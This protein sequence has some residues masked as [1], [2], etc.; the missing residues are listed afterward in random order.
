MWGLQ[1]I[2]VGI[3]NI[4]MS[5]VAFFI[6]LRFL[7]TLFGANTATPFVS[8]VYQISGNL[9]YPF[10]GIFPNLVLT[11]GAAIDMVAIVALVDYSVIGY[12]AISVLGSL[13]TLE[14]QAH[15]H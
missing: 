3:I 5:V 7:L 10:Q 9:V 14:R 1:N 4:A 11:G 6:G 15:I 2:A 12:L 8:W 13:T